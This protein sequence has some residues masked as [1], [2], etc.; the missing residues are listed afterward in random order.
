MIRQH[1]F[2]KVELVKLVAPEQSAAALETLTAHAE[3]IL[4]APRAALS[5]RLALHGRSRVL[6]ARRPTTSRSGFRARTPTEISSCSN[7]DAFQARRASIRFRRAEGEKPE[8]VHTL[9]GSGLPVG[10]TIVAILE[11]FQR[12]DGS[13]A[14]PTALQPYMRGL[15][16]IRRAG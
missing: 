9:N 13:V 3:E 10:R 15:T 4:P 16:E 12:A 2:D 14:I 8:F 5:G 6:F 1:Q 7:F 11:N